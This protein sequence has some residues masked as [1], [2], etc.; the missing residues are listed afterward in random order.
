MGSS[1]LCQVKDNKELRKGKYCMISKNT[2]PK[3]GEIQI[4]KI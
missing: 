4:I 2:C 1:D 3:I